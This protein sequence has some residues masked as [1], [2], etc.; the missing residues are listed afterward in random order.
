MVS[1]TTDTSASTPEGSPGRRGLDSLRVYVSISWAR[2]SF[3]PSALQLQRFFSK[4]HPAGKFHFEIHPEEHA[5]QRV[6]A[7]AGRCKSI[8]IYDIINDEV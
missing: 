7:R 8:R 2:K 1:L 5:Y 4:R 3:S 6:E